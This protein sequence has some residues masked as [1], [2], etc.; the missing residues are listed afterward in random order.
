[1]SKYKL[2]IILCLLLS[3]SAYSQIN[4][5]GVPFITNYTPHEYGASEQNWAIA[6]DNRG[7]MYFGN[8]DHGIL[9]YDGSTWRKIPVSNKSIVRSLAVDAFGTVYVGAVSEFGYLAPDDLG[10]M[11]YNSFLNE[12]D[13]ADQD[14]ADIFKIYVT[15]NEVVFGSREKLFIYD[16]LKFKTINLSLGAFFSYAINNVIFNGHF[17]EGLMILKV[18]SL[19]VVKGGDF[20]KRKGIFSIN[21]YFD[22]QLLIGTGSEG[23]FKFNISTASVSGDFQYAEA[24][25]YLKENQLYHAC[26]LSPTEYAFATLQKG[27]IIMD[28]FGNITNQFIKDNGLQ[29]ETVINIYSNTESP[30][31]EPLW[32]AL[33]EGIT[34]IEINSPLRKFGEEYDL[35]G[36][37][38]DIIRFNDKI[39][40]ATSLGVYY[41]N[42]TK[43]NQPEFKKVK[44]INSGSEI[45]GQT[46]SLVKFNPNGLNDEF[47]LVGSN[48]GLYKIDKSLKSTY[49][50]KQIRLENEKTLKN[51]IIQLKPSSKIKNKIYVGCSNRFFSIE[52]NNGVFRRVENKKIVKDEIR[53]ILEDKEGNVWLSTYFNGLIYVSFNEKDTV[54]FRYDIH[55]GLPSNK[56]IYIFE[57][58]DNLL[59][60]TDK[61]I[62][63][64]NAENKT[65][66]PSDQFK[67]SLV[68]GSVGVFR[69]SLDKNDIYWISAFN[70]NEKWIERGININSNSQI[71]DMTPF[72]RF[73]NEQIDVI[74]H[75]IDEITWMGSSSGLYSYNNKYIKNYYRPYNTLIRK[76]FAGEDSV[77]FYGTNYKNI[78]GKKV[79]TLEQPG[80]INPVLDYEFN[81]MVFHF[82]APYFEEEQ[83]IE[84]RYLLKGYK[85]NWSKWAKE[86]KAVY[87]NLNESS[88]IFY[89]KAKNIYNVE[90]NIASFHFT[91]LPP[92][93]RTILAYVI[94]GI[95]VIVFMFIIIK[96]YT[97]KL[98][99]EKIRLEGI[100]RERTA[101]VVKQKDEIEEQKQH[102][103][104]SIKYA[105]RIQHAV[106]PTAEKAKEILPEHFI[107]W[108]PRDIVSGDFWWMTEKD[109]KIV[110]AAA[111]CTGHG[112]P[113]AFMSMLGVSFLNEI[114]NKK[115]ITTANVILNQLR[116]SVK[117]TLDQT[118]EKGEAK[119]GMDIALLI[120]DIENHKI[121][122]AGAYNPLYMYRNNELIE[123]K[124]D[125][126]P[127]GIFIKEKETFT[128][129]EI[130]FQKDDTFYIFSDGYVD[131]FG[132]EKGGKFMSKNF[133]QLL[134]DI[135]VKPMAEQKEILNT[136]IDKW[137]GERQQVDD[138]IIVGIRM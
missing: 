44:G 8:N 19:N 135:Q 22:D 111:D 121:Q 130:D 108:R 102:I 27:A 79:I 134:L 103:E 90:S 60:G 20:F 62:Y 72:K 53:N 57:L 110:I 106:V 84:Y 67:K 37:V 63:T 122:Y 125:K 113:G 28:Q 112:V 49:I 59:F 127:I 91:I 61:G 2:L 32:L 1:M 73:P 98:E 39:F 128:N 13:S 109:N 15:D 123:T 69:L 55:N 10:K 71:S 115:E 136:E 36:A 5:Y 133:K 17:L 92:W 34:K 6:Q 117:T 26:Q 68:D 86:P 7:V 50:D 18:D 107:L 80:D 78:E 66:S 83:E 25:N 14:F 46:Q 40:I 95:L 96:L 87:T 47:L 76:V 3:Y 52:Y 30:Y 77:I 23:L 51:D 132:G 116:T 119:D 81:N 35:M 104:D 43:Q 45:S 85:D 31:E 41:L 97:H 82:A 114:V 89:V 11:Q 100:V 58:N 126:N 118:G 75:D 94:Y 21:K 12:L 105:Q 65:F 138:I 131:Q 93:Y 124:A 74:Y 137:R 129:H 54:I 9:E 16:Y 38:N 88:Y 56:D 24:N 101:E 48:S 4:K 64:F 29:D 42:Y 120:L 33:N 99:L 70:E